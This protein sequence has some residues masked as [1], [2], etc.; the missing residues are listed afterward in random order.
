MALDE[1]KED[2]IFYDIDGF[3]YIINKDFLEKVKP[4]TIDF[5][6]MGFKISSGM[7]SGTGCKSCETTSSCCS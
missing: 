3:R 1:L 6:P 4:I 7:D 5:S 2:D